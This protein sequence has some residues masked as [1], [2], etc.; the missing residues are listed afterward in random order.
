MSDES[1]RTP[2]N[3]VDPPVCR[4]ESDAPVFAV[5]L[6]AVV[7]LTVTPVPD[8]I[9]V[10]SRAL[11]QGRA[12]GMLSTFGVIAG[13]FVHL[14][15]AALG[16]AELFR[17]A[18]WAFDLV[19]YLGAAYLL[20]L[21][22]RVARGHDEVGFT[23]ARGGKAGRAGRARIFFQGLTTNLLNP[24]VALF[25]LSILPQFVDPDRGSVALQIVL[26]GSCLNGFG[27]L[28]KLTVALTAG[29][30]GDWLR[31]HPRVQRIQAWALESVPTALRPKA[32]LRELTQPFRI[33]WYRNC[34]WREQAH[35][36]RRT[37]CWRPFYPAST[38]ASVFR[39][40]S[41]KWLTAPWM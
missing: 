10:A 11:G 30:L 3:P 36:Q 34:D 14:G 16:L 38:N 1:W 33:G 7:T 17:Y 8:M 41:L 28:V 25:Y 23:A 37:R 32:G 27:L 31:R 5:F 15:L 4:S 6:A 40:N 2:S 9:Y 24:K 22:W 12:A 18:P 39:Q 13:T 26:L 19:R 20:Y 35:C 21:A 29:G